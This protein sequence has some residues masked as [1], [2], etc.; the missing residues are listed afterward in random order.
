MHTELMNYG[1]IPNWE[2][3]QYSVPEERKKLKKK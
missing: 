1:K 2:N 3:S